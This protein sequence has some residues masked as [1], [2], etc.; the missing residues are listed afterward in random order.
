MNP[1]IFLFVIFSLERDLLLSITDLPHW[2]YFRTPDFH[3]K[4]CLP[5]R[6]Q[7]HL[8]PSLRSSLGSKRGWATLEQTQSSRVSSH[9]RNGF[10]CMGLRATNWPWNRFY[11]RLDS[12]IVKVLI[13]SSTDW[14]T[15]TACC[16][17]SLWGG[18]ISSEVLSKH[19]SL[20]WFIFLFDCAR[21]Y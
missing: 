17:L 3:H 6:N 10:N 1:T 7:A 16:P 8:P 9:L 19:R 5:L 2:H 12:H 13:Q 4:N 15:Q 21:P 20:S 11:H 18:G 14:K